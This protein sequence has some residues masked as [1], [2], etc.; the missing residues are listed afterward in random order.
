M[1][2]FL[3]VSVKGGR[4]AFID[5]S[6]VRGAVAHPKLKPWD[7]SSP[8]LPL[9]AFIGDNRE[10]EIFGPSMI[11]FLVLC[12][13]VKTRSKQQESVTIVGI[14]NYNVHVVK[15]PGGIDVQ[16]RYVAEID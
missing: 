4:S 12:H 2:G 3:E 13:Q 1:S 14:E 6:L 5:A 16:I 11:E 15:A 9:L 10:L 7:A 8:E